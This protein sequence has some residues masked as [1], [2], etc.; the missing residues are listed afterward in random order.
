MIRTQEMVPDYYIEKSRD[1]Q[2]LC[3]LYDFVLNPVKY[4]ADTLLDTTDTAKSKRLTVTLV[5]R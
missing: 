3:R 4:N 1:F 5:G 2:I